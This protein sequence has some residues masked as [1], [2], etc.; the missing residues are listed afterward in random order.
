MESGLVQWSVR[1]WSVTSP[2]I[3]TRVAPPLLARCFPDG[4]P[5]AESR[6]KSCKAW[7]RALSLSKAYTTF[8]CFVGMGVVSCRCSPFLRMQLLPSI[9]GGLQLSLRFFLQPGGGAATEAG[10]P[11]DGTA[12]RTAPVGSESSALQALLPL[13]GV[14]ALLP[15]QG[16]FRRFSACVCFSWQ[17]R[18]LQE[19]LLAFS[20]LSLSFWRPPGCDCRFLTLSRAKSPGP[21][22][23]V[24]VPA[25][26]PGQGREQGLD[27]VRVEVGRAKHSL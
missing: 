14:S 21:P 23:R 16:P 15:G 22:L 17:E 19:P 20:E 7:Q 1:R 12:P 2:P 26:A 3:V 6:C 5:A 10:G 8:I 18:C 11:A 24:A 27:A 4:A 25:A 13:P 9:G